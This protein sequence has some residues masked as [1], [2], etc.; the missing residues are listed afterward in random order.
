ML[1]SGR[2]QVGNSVSSSHSE[3]TSWAQVWWGHSRAQ[4]GL[5]A[6][7]SS[8]L[9]KMA[10]LLKN[11]VVTVVN[12]ALTLWPHFLLRTAMYFWS[13]LNTVLQVQKQICEKNRR[14]EIRNKVSWYPD[15]APDVS[16]GNG[17]ALSALCFELEVL[18][19]RTQTKARW[20]WLSR[21]AQL[22]CIVD[23]N[24]CSWDEGNDG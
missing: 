11:P 24:T 22:I 4:E 9:L 10:V 16:T 6:Y 15:H 5:P 12:S 18:R 13:Y 7:S 3:W 19:Q 17:L 21:H 8:P 14:S 20:I 23:R 2:A 1:S